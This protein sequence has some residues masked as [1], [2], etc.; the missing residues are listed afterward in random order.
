MTLPS[1]ETLPD[2]E[3]NLLKMLTETRRLVEARKQQVPLAGLRALA[4]MQRRTL[5]L[6]SQLKHSDQVALIPRLRRSDTDTSQE[7]SQNSL[8]AKQFESYGVQAIALAVNYRFYYHS[9]ADLIRIAQASNVPIIR[10][11]VIF[12]EYQIVEARAAGADAV[13]LMATLL[14]PPNLR[15]LISITQRNRMTSIVQ[16]QNEDEVRDAI[17][18]EPQVIAISNRNMETYDIDL[19]TTARLRPLIPKHM[20]V[21]SVGGLHKADDVAHVY[22]AGLDGIII[23]YDLLLDDDSIDSLAR[24][25]RQPKVPL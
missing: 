16:V 11:D 21:V 8:M 12:D 19:D 18:F 23:G 1:N 5:D 20:A 4:G 10:Y 13:L 7:S 3:Y 17:E 2:S 24:L 6:S 25:F 22:Q 14:D 15:N 9:L